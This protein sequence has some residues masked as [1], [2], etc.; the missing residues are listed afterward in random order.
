METSKNKLLHCGVVRPRIEY[1]SNVWSPYTAKHRRLIE[2]IQ[3]RASKFFLN[4]L[5]HDI[6]Y[7]S[8]LTSLNLLPLEYRREIDLV[9]SH[10]HRS[11]LLNVISSTAYQPSVYT[12]L[13][14]SIQAIITNI[15]F[16]FS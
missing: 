15:I 10:E 6:S 1:A 4:H 2:K 11:G 8:R 5:I 3:S 14:I 9:L 16:N 13:A 7:K 12:Q